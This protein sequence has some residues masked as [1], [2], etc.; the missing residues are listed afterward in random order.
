MAEYA[1]PPLLNPLLSLDV[2]PQPE[3]GA[4]R[5]P[6]QWDLELP[7]VVAPDP[8]ARVPQPGTGEAEDEN[9]RGGRVFFLS[10]SAF[11]ILTAVKGVDLLLVDFWE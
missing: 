11:L 8:V 3:R 2:Q 4:T 9:A 6:V 1:Q 7:G 5:G 10:F